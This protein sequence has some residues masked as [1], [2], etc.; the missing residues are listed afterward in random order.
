MVRRAVLYLRSSKDR[1]DVS[2]ESQ[3]RELQALAEQQGCVVIDTFEDKVESAKTDD[4]PEFQRLMSEVKHDDCRFSVIYC[5]DTSRFSRRQYHAQM[6]KHL[7]KKHSIDLEYLKLPKTDSMLDPVIESIMEI[8]DEFHSQKSKMDGLRGMR[9]NILQGWRAGGRAPIGY[10]LVKH[11][12]GTRDGLPITKSKL[13]ECPTQFERVRSYLQE[14]AKGLSRRAAIEL[15]NL[16][17]A[18]STLSYVEDRLE[19]YCG[20]TVWNRLN[21]TIDGNY[22]GGRR[23]RDKSEWVIQRDTHPAMITEDEA[24]VIRLQIENQRALSAKNGG[25]DERDRY[26]SYILSP[27]MQCKCGAKLH[28]DSGYYRCSARCG[29]SGI[30]QST[31]EQLVLRFLVEELL[32]DSTIDGVYA[33]AK[34]RL[35]ERTKGLKSQQRKLASEV[36]EL[37]TEITELVALLTEVEHKRPLLD[38]IDSLES[39]R[40]QL[41][42][43]ANDITLPSPDTVVESMTRDQVQAY[44]DSLKNNLEDND[45]PTLRALVASLVKH[46][47]YTRMSIKVYC[48]LVEQPKQII[49]PTKA[50]QQSRSQRSYHD[51]TH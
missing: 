48:H 33:E 21:E 3:K 24:S 18:Y 2:I 27:L 14:R 34:K 20:H 5:Y 15:L 44:F 36:A 11:V 19:I 41:E 10:Q 50:Y 12:V 39:Q 23:V 13:E 16:D 17:I 43:V 7:L 4:R 26:S 35:D 51:Q 31:L 29:E 46:I 25:R 30:K 42:N 49:L 32:D 45:Y 47:D 22:V 37:N 40:T 38:R 9:E 8:F 1:H 28:G 6:Y